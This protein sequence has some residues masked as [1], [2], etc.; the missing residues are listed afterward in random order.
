MSELLNFFYRGELEINCVVACIVFVASIVSDAVSTLDPQQSDETPTSM[1]CSAIVLVACLASPPI[2]EKFVFV[3][4]LILGIGLAVVAFA[5]KHDGSRGVRIADAVFTFGIGSLTLSSFIAGGTNALNSSQK[6]LSKDAAPFTQRET[7]CSLAISFLF[8]SGCRIVRQAI[9]YPVNVQNFAVTT[10]DWDG[11]PVVVAGYAFSSVSSILSL[12]FG[13]CTASMLAVLLLASNTL[14]EL[15]TGGKRELMLS[16]GFFQLFAAFWATV[17]LSEQHSTLSVL[18]SSSACS[19]AACPASGAARRFAMLNGNP[20]G[21]WLNAIGT[22]VLAYGPQTGLAG[23]ASPAQPLLTPVVIVWGMLSTIGCAAVVFAYSSFQDAG[24][25]VEIS[26][27]IALVGIAISAFWD[28]KLG[29]LVFLAGIGYDELISVMNTSILVMLSFLTHCSI[30]VGVAALFLRVVLSIVVDL[31]WTC[32]PPQ[33][34]DIMDDIVGILTI[35]GM[36]IFTF[37]YFATTCLLSTYDGLLLGPDSYEDGPNKYARSMIAAVLEHW[38]PVLIFMPLFRNKQVTNVSL[39]WKI[40]A[41][42]GTLVFTLGLWITALFISGQD[43]DHADA[44]TWS[45]HTP[46]VLSVF[47][48]CLVPWFVVSLI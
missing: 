22:F 10:L 4:R 1:R 21:V 8:Y 15:G 40:G 27:L 39:G 32:F 34:T 7:V 38:L 2:K 44:Y 41:W 11:Q 24:I 36:S 46:F 3:Q 25:Y 43:A 30:L 12:A 45:S 18:F 26:M 48:V 13:G 6:S 37:L 16:C 5:G 31:G 23:D 33:I 28:T 42:V 35:C 20:T 9:V 17:A 19:S 29:S 14:R 47:F